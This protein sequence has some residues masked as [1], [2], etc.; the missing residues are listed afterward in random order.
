MAAK[1]IYF[2][3]TAGSGKSTLTGAFQLWLNNEGYDAVTV[4]LDPGVESLTYAPDVDIRDWIKLPEI[5]AEHGL[6]PNGAQIAAADMLALNIKEVADVI[7]QF[8]SDFILI[9]TP[10]QI[11]LFTFRQSSRH[12]IEALGMESSALAFL[13]DPAV[14][15]VPNGYV[16][17]MLLS[18]TVHFRLPLPTINV[19]AKADM[20]NDTDRERLQLWGE[21]Y[22]ALFN[23]LVDESVDSQTPV[24]VEFLQAMESVGASKPALFV[25]SDTGEG[26]EDI[27]SHV[28]AV[29][30]GGEDVDK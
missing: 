15:R 29:F 4:N 22:Y 7:S 9:D 11:E 21:D 12:I 10:G 3:G 8:N 19:I 24:N 28:Q 1:N 14:I 2:A 23:A 30:E 20:L 26:M 25:S 5:M 16:S 13:F 27:Y 6:G 18:T 17:S